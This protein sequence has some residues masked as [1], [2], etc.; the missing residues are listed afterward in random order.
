MNIV[1]CLGRN[2]SLKSQSSTKPGTG[3]YLQQPE[4]TIALVL[5]E[6]EQ[7]MMLFKSKPT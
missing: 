6:N 5:A 2:N 4:D 3:L 1:A 7:Q